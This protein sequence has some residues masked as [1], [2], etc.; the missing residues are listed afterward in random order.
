M[1]RKE[2]LE[3]AVIEEIKKR[4]LNDE[5]LE[6]L[7]KIA[8]EDIAA[9]SE[10][11]R[12]RL[13]SIDHE[14]NDVRN[15]LDHLYDALETGKFD[16]NDLAPRIKELKGRQDEL[17]KAKI[18]AEAEMTVQGV[19]DLNLEDVKSDICELRQMLEETEIV[20]RK[21]FLRSFIKKIVIDEDRATIYYIL[22]GLE[23]ISYA[24]DNAVLPI[25][26]SGGDRGIRT[27]DLRDA[28]AALSLL[29]YIPS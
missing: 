9:A 17:S 10:N 20:E 8:N 25:V 3:K 24:E 26:T 4:V 13:S 12:E 18:L 14:V 15:R 21:S 1:I 7:V 27:P 29:S 6:E 11:L 16:Y 19:K 23:D 28:N 5:N 22:P 2:Y